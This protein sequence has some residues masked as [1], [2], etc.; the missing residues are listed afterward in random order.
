[1]T[2]HFARIAFQQRLCQRVVDKISAEMMAGSSNNGISRNKTARGIGTDVGEHGNETVAMETRS[3][4]FI[5]ALFVHTNKNT[6]YL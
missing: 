5:Y 6:V 4:G 3:M 1:M 2:K